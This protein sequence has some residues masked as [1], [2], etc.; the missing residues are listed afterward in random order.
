MQKL[1]KEEEEMRTCVSGFIYGS[2]VNGRNYAC[3]FV[4]GGTGVVYLWIVSLLT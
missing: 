1:K 2:V 3:S 4:V